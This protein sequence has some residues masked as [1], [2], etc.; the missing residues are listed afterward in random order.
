MRLLKDSLLTAYRPITHTTN[1]LNR[2]NAKTNRCLVNRVLGQ[3]PTERV[4]TPPPHNIIINR[5]P[6]TQHARRRDRH[7]GDLG[8]ARFCAPAR[9]QAIQDSLPLL[10]VKHGFPPT[11]PNTYGHHGARPIRPRPAALQHKRFAESK[12]QS[13]RRRGSRSRSRGCSPWSTPWAPIVAAA[14]A[15]EEPSPAPPPPPPD[16]AAITAAPASDRP[17]PA[18]PAISRWVLPLLLPRRAPVEGGCHARARE[19]GREVGGEREREVEG[20]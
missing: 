3:A 1:F 8:I 2:L 17:R 18:P 12:H 9:A 6:P 15:E 5:S 10:A 16:G 14:A 13:P 4:I 19:R 11:R 20:E 7:P